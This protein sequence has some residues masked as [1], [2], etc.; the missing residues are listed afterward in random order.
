MNDKRNEDRSERPKGSQET[1]RRRWLKR[2]LLGVLGAGLAG[3]LG[4][5][6]FAHRGDGRGPLD[7]A[8]L[9][10][11]L[12]RM[13]RH[14]YVEIDA[15][16]AQQA[17]LGPIVKQAATDLLPLRDRMRDARRQAMA[18]LTEESI[19]RAAIERLRLEQLQLAETGSK[20]L[21]EAI[22]DAAEVLTPEQRIRAAERLRHRRRRWH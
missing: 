8:E 10:A 17:Q 12:E 13:L 19:D 22:A 9:D 3:G 7:P 11:R 21:V 20:R 2:G 15:S 4:F 14:V 18:L 6:A 5:G 1:P 16:E